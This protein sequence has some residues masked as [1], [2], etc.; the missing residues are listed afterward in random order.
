MKMGIYLKILLAF[1]V[2]WL[3]VFFIG[4]Y[5]LERR[6]LD[7]ER[8]KLAEETYADEYKLSALNETIGH[9]TYRI[10]TKT[11]AVDY[12]SVTIGGWVRIADTQFST[13]PAETGKKEI[14]KMKEEW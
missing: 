1:V 10:N 6:K 5:D 2:I 7:L 12:F 14:K 11:G 8:E 3:F 4:N 9:T 13:A